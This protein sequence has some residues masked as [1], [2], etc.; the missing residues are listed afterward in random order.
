MND[1]LLGMLGLAVRAGKVSFGVFSTLKAL[2][3]GRAKVVIASGDIGQSNKR[4][5]E[6]KCNEWDIPL[7]F[8]S[9]KE[10]LSRACGKKDMPVVGIC[11]EG[12]SE[13]I[14]KIYGGAQK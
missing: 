1:R 6:N 14:V 12:F 10:D 7:L 4:A 13:A 11:D 9:N 3:E 8:Y 5:V 2:D